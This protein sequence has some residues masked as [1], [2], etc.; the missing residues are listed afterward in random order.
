MERRSRAAA[1]AAAFSACFLALAAGCGGG[2]IEERRALSAA[3]MD[4][5][6]TTA[7]Q[8]QRELF[9]GRAR[10]SRSIDELDRLYLEH[11]RLKREQ[12]VAELGAVHWRNLRARDELET[13]RAKLAS[14]DWE[15]ANGAFAE[16]VAGCARCHVQ[17]NESYQRREGIENVR[18]E[19]MAGAVA[20]LERIRAEGI[21]AAAQARRE[22]AVAPSRDAVEE[23]DGGVE[24]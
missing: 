10:V 2:P 18:A 20:E 11:L 4:S 7:I 9:A 6:A 8:A 17:Y 14:G 22:R 15:G 3:V 21:A 1:S 16:V 5:V 24:E 13:V 23:N 12:G 19:S